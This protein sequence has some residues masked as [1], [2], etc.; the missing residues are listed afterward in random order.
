[1][2]RF[3]CHYTKSCSYISPLTSLQYY[4][5]IIALIRKLNTSRKT[6]VNYLFSYICSTFHITI[7]YHLQHALWQYEQSG[8]CAHIKCS[9]VCPQTWWYNKENI[10][11]TNNSNALNWNIEKLHRNNSTLFIFFTV[12]NFSYLYTLSSNYLSYDFLIAV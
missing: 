3:V 1:M 7:Y 8:V 2:Q 4:E 9:C 6:L 12:F 5:F 11:T 10:W